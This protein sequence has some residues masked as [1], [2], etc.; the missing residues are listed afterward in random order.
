MFSVS[1]APGGRRSPA[2]CTMASMP[3]STGA[4]FH[5][6]SDTETIAYVIPIDAKN[7]QYKKATSL[8]ARWPSLRKGL[9]DVLGDFL[10]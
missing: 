5:T 2:W 10:L 8:F 3:S 6:T 7:P 4:I 9:Y 1:T